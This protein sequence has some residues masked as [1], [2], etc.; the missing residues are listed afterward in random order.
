MKRLRAYIRL[1][2]RRLNRS[3]QLQAKAEMLL[4]EILIQDYSN[5]EIAYIVSEIKSKALDILADRLEGLEN[6]KT[7]TEYAIKIL[8]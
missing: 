2:R 6:E 8:S 1:K 4:N 5:D 7:V 3:E